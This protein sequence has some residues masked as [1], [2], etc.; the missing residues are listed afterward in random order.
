M[1]RIV[2]HTK[3]LSVALALALA[4]APML[5]TGQEESW[6]A[7]HLMTESG[8]DI[9]ASVTLGR[10]LDLHVSVGEKVVDVPTTA[11]DGV[12]E[13]RLQAVRVI[14]S[15][16]IADG[17]RVRRLIIEIPHLVR[18]KESQDLRNLPYYWFVIENGR[19]VRRIEWCC[20]KGQRLVEEQVYLDKS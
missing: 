8:V 18:D 14:H 4:A 1:L 2:A 17:R 20:G 13:P 10:G 3:S 16:S 11:L 6:K 9:R 5:S 15:S 19:L 7:V 12:F